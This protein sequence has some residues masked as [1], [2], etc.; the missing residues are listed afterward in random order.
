MG[1]APASSVPCFGEFEILRLLGRGGVAEV[2]EAR[3]RGAY[4]FEKRFALKRILPHVARDT[5]VLRVF[6]HQARVHA[7]LTH[8]NLVALVEFGEVSDELYVVL[9]FVDGFS[10]AELVSA[11]AA[12][13][14]SMELGPA[15]YIA[16]E[17]LRALSHVHAAED[18]AGEPLALVHR[19]VSPS[20]VLIAKTGDVKL[21]D[22]GL[23]CGAMRLPHGS[24]ARKVGYLSPEQAS[25]GVVDA[26]SDLFSLS[27]L[28]AE[29]LIGA[30]VFPGIDQLEVLSQL[31]QRGIGALHELGARLPPPLRALLS[32]G[33]AYDPSQRFASAREY[34]NELDQVAAALGLR[35]HAETLSTWMNELGLLTLHSHIRASVRPQ[36][37]SLAPS[38]RPSVEPLRSRVSGRVPRQAPEERVTARPPRLEREPEVGYRLRRAGGTVIGPLRL[39][40]LLE[41]IATARLGDDTLVARNDGPFLPLRSVQEL[42][43][44]GARA[45]YRF[46]DFIGLRASERQP[47]S[48]ALLP[49]YL[50]ELVR[51]KR[52][53][54]LCVRSA[55]E[56]VRVYYEQ[57][58]PVFSTSSDPEAL[59]GAHLVARG[60]TS[61]EAMERLL[62]QGFRRGETLGAALVGADV[63]S[64][65][66]LY[67]L[68]DEQRQ[69]RFVTFC[70]W[71]DGEILFADGERSGEGAVPLQQHP[72]AVVSHALLAAYADAEI[73]QLLQGLSRL[74]VTRNSREPE[75]I[76]KLGLAERQ[77]AVLSSLR[78]P[79]ELERFARGVQRRASVHA[80]EVRRALFIGLASGAIEAAT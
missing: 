54:L 37:A 18:D 10:C 31:H 73:A 33:L 8:P 40:R 12:R 61:S 28:L 38:V 51:Q 15:L 2:Y 36:A 41:M 17:V 26:R 55:R 44:L 52:S 39:A 53:G 77:H 72:L 7:R 56:Q 45:A 35:L 79:L 64:E 3:R 47:L 22:L 49:R 70:R 14:L 5:T 46:G 34:L 29:L 19:N 27:V 42:A 63:L 68:L 23:P 57:G 30:P 4:G 69:R 75:L 80:T 50:F 1:V 59:L 21:G 9:E 6:S 20:N 11:A 58:A 32:R 60:V 13:G 74:R 76:A 16:R 48:R 43:R 62:E 71:Q 25:F 67:A 78:E 66:Q 65:G 24:L